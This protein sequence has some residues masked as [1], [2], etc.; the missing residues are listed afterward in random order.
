MQY[1]LFEENKATNATCKG[2]PGDGAEMYNYIGQGK[3]GIV[4]VDSSYMAGYRF[5][6]NALIDLDIDIT[7]DCYYTSVVLCKTQKITAKHTAKCHN[8][9]INLLNNLKPKTV[10]LLGEAGFE[11]VLYP[12]II[13]GRIRN[14]TY[15]DFI[16]EVVP[17]KKYGKIAVVWHP[18]YLTETQTYEDG[19]KSNF[20][21]QREP[22][23]YTAWKQNLKD[24]IY[25]EKSVSQMPPVHKIYTEQEAIECLV[26][27]S[28]K[29][30]VAFDYETTGIKP[31]REGQRI[32][33]IAVSDGKETCSFPWFNTDTFKNAMA[34]F[35]DSNA[36]KIAHNMQFEALWSLNKVGTIGRNWY[37]DTQ[38]GQ[39]C[40]HSSK[41]NGLKYLIYCKFGIIGYDNYADKFMMD[42]DIEGDNGINKLAEADQNEILYYNALDAYFTYKL[43][44]MQ[45]IE[46]DA[47]QRKGF[48][49]LIKTALNFAKIT[50]HGILID[51]K[52]LMD[53]INDLTNQLEN[54]VR[55]I[56]ESPALKKWDRNDPFNINSTQHI[57]HLLFDIMKITPLSYTAT[58]KPELTKD[59]LPLYKVPIVESI[60]TYRK[61]NKILNTYLMQYQRELVSDRVN[62]F[63]Y[64]TRVVT[65]RTSAG[66][67]NVQNT[68]KRDKNSMHLIRSFILP[69]KGQIIT[70][71]DFK[72]LELT[73]STFYHKDPTFISYMKDTSKDM[74]ADFAQEVFLLSKEEL[75][76]TIR[77]ATKGDFSF[78]CI[79]GSYPKD[80]AVNLWEDAT[81][82]GLL[83]H[84]K[85]KGIGDMKTFEKHVETVFNRFWNVYFP[86][87]RD[88][89]KKIY[90]DYK[91]NG[92]VELLTGF[93]GYGPMRRNN[94]FNTPTQG[95]GAHILLYVLNHVQ[96]YIETNNLKSHILG[97]VHDSLL[98]SIEPDE[99]KLIDKYISK[100]ISEDIVK[101]WP[102]INVPLLME[103]AVSKKSWA[104]IEDCGYIGGEE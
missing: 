95:T 46:L 80:M 91:Q 7:T 89:R 8:N 21:Y 76:K 85:S 94:V 54:A 18:E 6:Q 32:L 52:I 81:E 41:P 33:T 74:H 55:A 75:K 28:Q 103:K 79:Y 17:S 29:P 82:L 67:P 9:L 35:L 47:L 14:S 25:S 39:H 42:N 73:V 31:F 62:P 44:E 24:A 100:V 96:E 30:F 65:W 53:N 48:N 10:I 98:M 37:W 51:K 86:V 49:L 83:D 61:I 20:L 70:E 45:K 84:L 36:R 58:G 104:D 59:T 50:N 101:D 102:W 78:A 56:D 2:C 22:W 13:S 5:L 38:I 43:Y 77:Q 99:E 68:I 69:D 71:Y 15:T 40:L 97:E 57:G 16:G 90:N 60:L 11:A 26:K 63:F 88:Y 93:R 34:M 4:I 64:L 23:I 72:G 3:K 92:Y 66:S 1:S 12:T 87:Y 19:T 27:F